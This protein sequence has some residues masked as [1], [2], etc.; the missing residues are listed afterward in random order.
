VFPA[1][2]NSAGTRWYARIPG[3]PVLRAD[4]QQSM[5]ELIREAAADTAAARERA[6]AVKP[7]MAVKLAEPLDFGDGRVHDTLT[8]VVG[9]TFRGPDGQLYKVPNWRTRY[10]WEVA[11]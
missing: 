7:G 9:S 10:R 8:M 4:T 1:D 3:R 6:R 2:T 5:R 11:R